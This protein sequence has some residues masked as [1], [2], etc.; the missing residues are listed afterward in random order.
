MLACLA[1]PG[2]PVNSAGPSPPKSRNTRCQQ[3]C[4]D[5]RGHR[6]DRGWYVAGQDRAHHRRRSCRAVAMASGETCPY[7]ETEREAT[8]AG[9]A[10]LVGQAAG[11]SGAHAARGVLRPNYDPQF[12]D[13][14]HGFRPGRGCHTALSEVVEVWKG[15]HWFIEGDIA[16]CF[17]SLDRQV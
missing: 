6:R 4:D 14:A 10:D 17:D 3:G 7:P 16:Q 11:R 8:R 1:A 2:K 13:H 15:T 5:A 9:V 12:S